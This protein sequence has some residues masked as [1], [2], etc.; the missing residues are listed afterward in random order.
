MTYF[1]RPRI[2][3][4]LRTDQLIRAFTV[5][6]V[7]VCFSTT[8]YAQP[9]DEQYKKQNRNR[10][11]AIED[12]N[13]QEAIDYFKEYLEK[14]PGDL[15]SR[16]GLAVAYA[17]QE[18]IEQ[19]MMYVRKAVEHGLPVERFLAGP[20][21]LLEPLLSSEAFTNYIR[22][23]YDRLIHGPMLGQVTDTEASVWVRTYQPSK[24]EVGVWEA[25][26]PGK[27][28]RY[29]GRTEKSADFTGIVDLTGLKP[30]TEYRYDVYVDGS[31]FFADG[32]F[33]TYPEEGEEA[34]LTV[35]FAG[36]AGYTPWNEHAWDTLRTHSMDAFFH[37]GDNVYIDHP[38]HPQV[39]RYCYYRRQSRPEYRRFVSDVSNYAIWDD[40]DF[41]V[42]DGG[43][44]PHVD[45]PYWKKEVW[46][47][48]KH[49]WNNPYYGGGAD[50]PG[51]WFDV[52]MGD[53]DVFFLDGRYYREEPS[54]HDNPSMLGNH[55]KQWLKEKLRSSEATFKVIATPVPFAE[56]TKP[57]SDDPWQGYP[58]EREEIFSF[59]E[60][61]Q[62]EGV[63]LVSADRHR[64]DAW[65]IERPDGYDFYELMSS[66]LTNFHTHPIMEKSLFGYNE[67]SF[68]VL[69]ID[70]T[71]EDPK[72]IYS[73]Y[74]IKND[75][76][77]QL[78]IYRSQLEFN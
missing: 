43:G 5:F 15:E 56:G 12:G 13:P 62:I 58:E 69:K 66:K 17:Y 50:Q 65:E 51:V 46:E 22:G 76:I 21:A 11:A 40:H 77:H 74:N 8:C 37:M 72:I 54:E 30:N 41:T 64:S 63:V 59:I 7:A 78:T 16:Y 45:K 10:I 23:R 48:F 29:S 44:S 1:G 9:E 73:I 6:F 71:N 75:L 28:E 32:S 61:H 60:D 57:G 49:Q 67:N 31:R 52:S 20:R 4:L 70:T 27:E 42:N 14:Y 3:E 24:I 38:E 53:I 68:G 34:K 35:G 47:L 55:Q 2:E 26:N 39:Q 33:R 18:E 25:G 36:G 19:S